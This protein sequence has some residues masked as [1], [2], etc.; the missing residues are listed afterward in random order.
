MTDVITVLDVYRNKAVNP[1]KIGKS[2]PATPFLLFPETVLGIELEIEQL[3][4]RHFD[5]YNENFANLWVIVED[6]SLRLNGREF[7]SKPTQ[8]QKLLEDLND[9]FRKMDFSD[10]DHYSDRTSVHVHANVQHYTKDNLQNLVVI[11][12]LLERVLFDFVGHHR[13]EGLYCVPLNETMLLQDLQRTLDRIFTGNRAAWEKYTALNLKPIESYGTVEFRHMH[14]TADMGKL[15]NWITVITNLMGYC[16]KTPLSQTY[17]DIYGLTEQNHAAYYHRLI[18]HGIPYTP[19]ISQKFLTSVTDT[20]YLLTQLISRKKD[21]PPVKKEAEPAPMRDPFA[22][23]LF[24]DVQARELRRAQ[25]EIMRRAAQ[26]QADRFRVQVNAGA[27]GRAPVVL[28]NGNGDVVENV[29]PPP[30]RAGEIPAQGPQQPNNHFGWDAVLR[31]DG[32][33][34]EN[35]F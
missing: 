21:K 13:N 23:I 25:D 32:R 10:N 20:K 7:V 24:A 2:T 5:V 34:R 35:E 18:P 11:Y 19:E 22:E 1:R 15:T 30:R 3:R 9:F 14:G 31:E 4:N 29:A 17:E 12:S 27:I 26:F 33:N 16:A 8:A 6:H 28:V